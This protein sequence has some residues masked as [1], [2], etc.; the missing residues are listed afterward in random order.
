MPSRLGPLHWNSHVAPGVRFQ[1]LW[2]T[3]LLTAAVQSPCCGRGSY[4]QLSPFSGSSFWA[5]VHALW[6]LLC[7]SRCHVAASLR[8]VPRTGV[9][10]LGPADLLG[11]FVEIASGVRPRGHLLG[12]ASGADEGERGQL[13]ALCFR[14][15]SS[16][17]PWEGCSY[18][19]GKPRCP[20]IPLAGRAWWG[21][22]TTSPGS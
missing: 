13:P 16:R 8:C 5:L 17:G 4:S 2:A 7:T 22:G 9:H 3:P 10:V 19:Q 21:G 20:C 11:F 6:L 14:G 12:G 1:S 15:S 18:I